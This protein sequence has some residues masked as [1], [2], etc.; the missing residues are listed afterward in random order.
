MGLQG[1]EG[2]C[3]NMMMACVAKRW[4]NTKKQWCKSCFCIYDWGS[5]NCPKCVTPVT[6]IIDN[7]RMP[8]P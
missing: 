4:K 5:K 7:N 2:E 1:K 3:Q 6:E 8:D